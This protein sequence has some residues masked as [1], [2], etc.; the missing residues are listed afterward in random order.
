MLRDLEG[1]NL[2]TSNFPCVGN[3][4]EGARTGSPPYSGLLNRYKN[5]P[6]TGCIAALAGLGGEGRGEAQ[7]ACLE[8]E[9][10]HEFAPHQDGG[11]RW[12][13]KPRRRNSGLGTPGLTQETTRPARRMRL[14]SPAPGN[15]KAGGLLRLQQDVISK[16]KK[17]K[18]KKK[19]KKN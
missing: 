18:L 1:G 14:P 10:Q 16:K 6:L 4:Q 15:W 19:R 5:I 9:L 12:K 7:E 3:P 17:K 11:S 2:S 8:A 13:T